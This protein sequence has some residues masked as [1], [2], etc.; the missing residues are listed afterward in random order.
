MKSIFI[1]YFLSVL[2]G[3]ALGQI[4]V[5]SVNSGPVTYVNRCLDGLE[6]LG[7]IKSHPLTQN[8]EFCNIASCMMLLEVFDKDSLLNTAIFE[9]LRQIA[10]KFH[11]EGTSVMISY[12]GMNSVRR[13]EELNEGKNPNGIT[14]VSMG[15][16]C[17][18]FGSLDKGIKEFNLE[19]KR[20]INSYQPVNKDPEDEN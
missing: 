16:S 13:S 5:D 10:R 12:P 4:P 3:Q 6:P 7:Y 8:Q 18:S 19:T 14:Y 20:L 9:R 11:N 15:N 1:L 2:A 17:L